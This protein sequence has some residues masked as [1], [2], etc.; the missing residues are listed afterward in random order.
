MEPYKT[1]LVVAGSVV[2]LG[3]VL[4]PIGIWWE[5]RKCEKPKYSLVRPLGNKRN[6]WNGKSPAELRQYAP[7]LLAEVT[8]HGTMRQA[9]SEGFKK[10]AN[11]IFG[12]NTPAGA[13]Q[14]SSS[15]KIAMTSPVRMEIEGS[16]KLNSS[17]KIAMT[18]PVRM[19]MGG[20]ESLSQDA[21]GTVTMSFVMPSKY[22]I[23]SLPKP[24]NPDVKI[25]E[26][27]G[28]LAAVL[29]FRGHIRGRKLVDRKKQELL[30]L[31]KAE[32]LVPVG[33]VKLYQYHPPFTYGWQRVNEVM[34]EVKEKEK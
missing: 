32:N 16:K 20:T 13:E 33:D 31:I 24:N 19:E 7:L 15:E 10:I 11:F 29:T 25:V 26:A 21:A 30:K 14:G 34:Y 23:N 27:P 18:S 12:N 17:E 22:N 1:A 5:V 28:H 6:W 8:V 3:A 4:W 2:G 9:S